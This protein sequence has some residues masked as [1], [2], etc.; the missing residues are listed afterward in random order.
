MYNTLRPAVGRPLVLVDWTNLHPFQQLIFSF[1]RDGRSLPFLCI[2]IRKSSADDQ[3]KGRMIAAEQQALEMLERFCPPDVHP[4]IIADR[5]FGHPRW[6]KDI[7]KRGW[8]FLQQLSHIHQVC[9]EQHMG[10]LKELGIRRG[11]CV[12]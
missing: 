6:L 11:R 3:T 12:L 4:I 1:P 8:C 10:T 7:Q 2:T 9:V 5:G